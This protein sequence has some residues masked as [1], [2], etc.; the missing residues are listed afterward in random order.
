MINI[1]GVILDLRDLC[2]ARDLYPYY[3]QQGGTRKLNVYLRA[4]FEQFDPN[5]QPLKPRFRKEIQNG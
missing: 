4:V 3:K 5:V 1:D 2:D